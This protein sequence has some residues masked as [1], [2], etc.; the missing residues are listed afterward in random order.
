[1]PEISLKQFLTMHDPDS[2]NSHLKILQK[3]NCYFSHQKLQVI[4]KQRQEQ[5]ALNQLVFYDK[6]ND[7]LVFECKNVTLIV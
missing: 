3:R 1:M 4:F 7:L 2:K 5:A 6:Y